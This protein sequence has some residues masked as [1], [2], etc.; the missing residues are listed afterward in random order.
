[1]TPRQNRPLVT[2]RDDTAEIVFTLCDPPEGD[3]SRWCAEVVDGCGR[4]CVAYPVLL[5]GDLEVTA[6]LDC[7]VDDLCPDVYDVILFDDCCRECGRAAYDSA[8]RSAT[9][10]RAFAQDELPSPRAKTLSL[11]DAASSTLEAKVRAAFAPWEGPDFKTCA[12]IVLGAQSV[13]LVPNPPQGVLPALMDVRISDG[14][15]TAVARVERVSGD[16]VLFAE[17][18]NLQQPIEKGATF[19]FLWTQDNLDRAG[20]RD[21]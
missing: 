18:L 2:A 4:V 3:L 21:G 9:S 10:A 1:M 19:S 7:A 14:S 17:P 6:R 20:G 8:K 5:T 15:S 13:A 11:P 16:R 12:R